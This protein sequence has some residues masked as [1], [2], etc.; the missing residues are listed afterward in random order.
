MTGGNAVFMCAISI[1]SLDYFVVVFTK[2]KLLLAINDRAV[3]VS[4]VTYA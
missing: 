3:I 4:V 2:Q 1:I